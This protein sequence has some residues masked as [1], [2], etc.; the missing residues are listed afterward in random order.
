MKPIKSIKQLNSEKAL[1][2]ERLVGL[3]YKIQNQWIAL[4]AD[5]T[6]ANI[7]KNTLHSIINKKAAPTSENDSLLKTVVHFGLD[8]LVNSLANKAGEKLGQLF[9]KKK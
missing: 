2:H 4:K 1:I 9:T 5:F 3:E 7:I 6:P 8:V